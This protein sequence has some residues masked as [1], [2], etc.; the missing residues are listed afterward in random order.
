VCRHWG[1]I[2][3]RRER[4]QHQHADKAEDADQKDQGNRQRAERIGARRAAQREIA[5]AGFQAAVR[6]KSA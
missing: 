1:R 3:D 6:A 4:P 5:H 2:A